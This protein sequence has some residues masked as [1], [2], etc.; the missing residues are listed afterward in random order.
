MVE[1]RARIGRQTVLVPRERRL[2]LARIAGA[3]RD[4]R[5]LLR[6]SEK[7][8][9]VA[10]IGG[11]DVERGGGIGFGKLLRW[12]ELAAVESERLRTSHG[13]AMAEIGRWPCRGRGWQCV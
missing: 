12:L 1:D 10:R 3:Q 2:H 7:L 5:L 11:E 8:G 4:E 6:R 13:R 9:L